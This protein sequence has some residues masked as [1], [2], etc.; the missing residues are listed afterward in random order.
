MTHSTLNG[1]PAG[2][3]T[4]SRILVAG[5]DPARRAAVLHDLS[6]SLPAGAQLGEAGAMEEVLERASSS[7]VVMLAGDIGGLPAES[8]MQLLGH[9]HP[10]LPVVALR[11]PMGAARRGANRRGRPTGAIRRGMAPAGR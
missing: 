6:E 3:D 11:R 10:D 5:D 8:A 7:S 2:A 9:R 1:S 4:G